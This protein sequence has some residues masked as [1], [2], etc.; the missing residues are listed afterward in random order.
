MPYLTVRSNVRIVTTRPHLST[1]SPENKQ[2]NRFISSLSSHRQGESPVTASAVQRVA[3][4]IG[5]YKH[6]RNKQLIK[7]K[8]VQDALH[9]EQLKD[10]KPMLP[11][12]S[13]I[14]D[15]S[16]GPAYC[17]PTLSN[18]QHDEIVARLRLVQFLFHFYKTR[19]E[20]LQ[21]PNPRVV[22][23]YICL[24]RSWFD[25]LPL[26]P[27]IQ[28]GEEQKK[29]ERLLPMLQKVDHQ[30]TWTLPESSSLSSSSSVP[31]ASVPSNSTYP[32]SVPPVAT[33]PLLATHAMSI[34]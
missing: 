23:H 19:M 15:E 16:N 12:A 4:W 13:K 9:S 5:H 3:E 2:W 29:L 31:V 8:M 14:A 21:L 34:G 17:K 25:I 28:D 26:F 11:W 6:I 32:S 30:F 7:T 1:A 33:T 27:M 20:N 18:E 10:L 24:V 22:Y